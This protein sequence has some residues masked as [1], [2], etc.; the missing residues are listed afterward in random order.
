[1]FHSPTSN[2]QSLQAFSRIRYI[3]VTI[4][5]SLSHLW[6]PRCFWRWLSRKM[7]ESHQMAASP[8]SLDDSLGVLSVIEDSR[9]SPCRILY[10][11][12]V[13]CV[14]WCEDAL[15]A[16]DI[17]TI[18]F[19][20]FLL[21]HNPESAASVLAS[22]RFNR[23]TPNP[24]LYD[25]PQMSD[26]VPLLAQMFASTVHDMAELPKADDVN[27]PGVI[28]LPAKYWRCKLPW[29]VDEVDNFIPPLSTLLNTL[30]NVWIDFPAMMDYY[31]NISRH[32]S[33]I[34]AVEKRQVH[35]ELLRGN[36]SPHVSLT[37]KK[38]QEHHRNIRNR[39]RLGRYEPRKAT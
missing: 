17:P 10:E 35:F 26:H 5:R 33:D 39:I 8:K 1:M 25:I 7:D 9:Y 28:L 24:R 15:T 32:T 36:D 13:P 3:Y 30:I 34:F 29:T 6:N 31:G 20:L 37:T 21:V 4:S 11:A 19:D 2:M 18:V 16:Y 22:H 38:C 14:I 12:G 27:A 23:T